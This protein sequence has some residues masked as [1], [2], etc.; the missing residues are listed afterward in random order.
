MLASAIATSN[1]DQ[2]KSSSRPFL[3]LALFCCLLFDAYQA[4]YQFFANCTNHLRSYSVPDS[5][6]KLCNLVLS[7]DFKR[8]DLKWFGK[9]HDATAFTRS[10]ESWASVS[11]NT[12]TRRSIRLLKQKFGAE[13]AYSVVLG[14]ESGGLGIDVN[15][16]TFASQC[17]LFPVQGLDLAPLR[18]S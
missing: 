13:A 9:S 7:I 12:I 5:F 17:V 1:A 15:A 4:S 18:Q 11:T 16:T 6:V 8:W 10:K 2:S 3:L 14:D